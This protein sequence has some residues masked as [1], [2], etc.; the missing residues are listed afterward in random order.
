MH[1]NY[2][3]EI[4]NEDGESEI[5]LCLKLYYGVGM[6]VN[7]KE[8]KKWGIVASE[9]GNYVAKG[10]RAFFGWKTQKSYET[11]FDYFKQ[12]MEIDRNKTRRDTS[13]AI[14]FMGFMCKNGL[15]IK[16]SIQDA[17]KFYQEASDMG[18]CMAMNNL[19]FMYEEA[20]GLEKN[21]KKAIQLYEKAS[22]LGNSMSMNNLAYMLKNGIE[23]Q[24]NLHKAIELYENSSALGNHTAIYNLACMYENGVDVAKNMG[25]A[26]ELY[27]KSGKLGN[28]SALNNLAYLYENGNGVTKDVNKAVELYS[29]ACEFGNS[30]AMCNLA[31]IYERGSFVTQDLDKAI[32][33]LNRSCELGLSDAHYRLAMIYKD[34]KNDPEKSASN[35]FHVANRK[36]NINCNFS[37]VEFKKFVTQKLIQ[38]TTEYHSLWEGQ[39]GLAE[40]IFVLL[41]VSKHRNS[42]RS[43]HLRHLTKNVTVQIVKYL[44][45][46]LQKTE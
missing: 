1:Q 7:S 2:G 5:I 28:S 22:I 9:K 24:K 36:E 37:K 23:V 18:N 40:K 25:M 44:C 17:V 39:E 32:T 19:A 38:W 14:N 27:A 41:L 31:I 6:Q 46:Y 15:G 3:K 35:F 42:S 26:V 11:A 34:F 30:R 16:K 12:S 13:F 45:H 4:E 8:S 10:V 20:L 21:I 33:L 29:Q 43:K